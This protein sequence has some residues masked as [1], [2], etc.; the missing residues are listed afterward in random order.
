MGGTFVWVE[1]FRMQGQRRAG[2][3]TWS[4]IFPGCDMRKCPDQNSAPEAPL[5]ALGTQ[6][7][8]GPSTP[9]IARSY[10]HPLCLQ[11]KLAKMPCIRH[12]FSSETK[13]FTFCPLLSMTLS[14]IHSSVLSCSLGPLLSNH[15]EGPLYPEPSHHRAL[16][17]S[18]PL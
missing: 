4:R 15:I 6:G 12:R 3:S 5:P 9:A 13:V 18:G 2:F 8:I 7:R 11:R 17:Q 10:F 1:G 16:T 14:V